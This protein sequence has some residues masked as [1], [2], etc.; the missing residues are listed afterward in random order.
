MDTRRRTR[1]D[2]ERDNREILKRAIRRIALTI[3]G[4]VGLVTVLMGIF[5]VGQYE[6][7]IITR[8]G[9]FHRIATPGLNFKMPWVDGAT[10]FDLRE[11]KI[12][13]DNMEAYT[14]DQQLAKIDYEAVIA[15]TSIHD[16]LEEIF[17]KYGTLENAIDAIVPQSVKKEMKVVMGKYTASKAIQE[18]GKLNA[19]VDDLIESAINASGY[20]TLKLSSITDIEFPKSYIE[21]V[22]QRMTAE[23]EVLRRKQDLEKEKVQADIIRTQADADAYKV[24]AKGKAEALAIE[25]VN[26]ALAKSPKYIDKLVAE[27]WDGQLPKTMVPGS[28]VPFIAVK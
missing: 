26:Q 13:L 17:T 8:Y 5:T 16:K 27:K 6:R 24:E 20:F 4:V 1:E 28:A 12:K 2:I 7:D 14:F 11:R 21:A 15:P 23:V 19:D 22:E 25:A 3:I 18:R 10:T 9:A